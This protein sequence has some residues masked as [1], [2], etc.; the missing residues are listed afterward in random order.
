MGMS[1]V[2]AW[3]RF[4][5]GALRGALERSET[6][7]S[8]AGM[9]LKDIAIASLEEAVNHLANI[10][11]G[12]GFVTG[13]RRVCHMH[14]ATQEDGDPYVSRAYNDCPDF[15][16]AMQGWLRTNV[17]EPI[18]DVVHETRGALSQNASERVGDVALQYRDKVSDLRATHYCCSTS[19]AFAHVNSVVIGSFVRNGSAPAADPRIQVC[20]SEL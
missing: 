13:V 5:G 19:L 1:Q 7:P 6:E 20:A 11:D 18:G 10:H 15:R 9:A 3:Q 4:V 12:P 17:V 16:A 8:C 2:K 14:A